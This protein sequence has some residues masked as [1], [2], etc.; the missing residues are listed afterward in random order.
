MKIVLYKHRKIESLLRNF[1]QQ[2]AVYCTTTPKEGTKIPVLKYCFRLVWHPYEHAKPLKRYHRD[3][4]SKA[5][6]PIN[7]QLMES[8]VHIQLKQT[9]GTSARILNF[10][11]LLVKPLY[12]SNQLVL[13][14]AFWSYRIK[15]QSQLK[16]LWWEI[17][18]F[19]LILNL[20]MVFHIRYLLTRLNLKKWWMETIRVALVLWWYRSW[21]RLKW[22]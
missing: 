13:Q 8:S 17:A 1:D 6:S 12:S 5:Q 16:I 21:R 9:W 22:S 2:E 15:P 10:Q 7:W 18:P 19:L 11:I 3:G 14:V 20:K 4:T